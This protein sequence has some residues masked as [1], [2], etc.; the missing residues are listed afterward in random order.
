LLFG[1]HSEKPVEDAL[2]QWAAHGHAGGA[3]V[4]FRASSHILKSDALTKLL[5][6]KGPFAADW[7]WLQLDCGEFDIYTRQLC[8]FHLVLSYFRVECVYGV[9]SGFLDPL[10][11]LGLQTFRFVDADSSMV[12][13]IKDWSA[14]LGL[15]PPEIQCIHSGTAASNKPKK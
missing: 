14:A 4:D 9:W 5:D 8:A 15:K 6:A 11:L 13:R 3:L 10:A 12:K 2:N 1:D 7:A